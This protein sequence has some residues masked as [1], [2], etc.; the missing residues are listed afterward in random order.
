MPNT[1]PEIP[2]DVKRML[3]IECG[4]R[5]AA[6][7]EATALEK[8]HIV[9]WGS[10]MEHKFENLV[11]L[12]AVCHKN[13]HDD[14]WDRLAMRGY[15]KRPWVSRYRNQ[16][17]HSDKAVVHL[18]LDLTPETFGPEEKRRVLVAVAAALDICPRDVVTLS[19][20]AGSVTLEL[21]LP[22]DAAQ[23]LLSDTKVQAA[24]RELVLPVKLTAISSSNLAQNAIT[25]TPT[26]PKAPGTG[27]G[28]VATRGILVQTLVALLGVAQSESSFTEITLEPAVGNEQ[29]DFLWK[30]KEGS[31]AT[32]VKS[33]GNSF[34]KAD[35]RKWAGELEAARS[36]EQCRLM[37]VGNMPSS[38]VGLK[39]VGAVA[40]ETK[41]LHLGDL[42]E[43]AAHRLAAFLENEQQPSGTAAER[44]MVVHGLTSKLQHLAAASERF[45]REEFIKLLKQWV[46]DAPRQDRPIEISRIRKYAPAYLIGRD[47][48]IQL[49]HDAWNQTILG[50]AKRPNILTFVAF[51]GEGKTSLVAKWAAE[52][53][54][55][56]WPGCAAAFAWSFYI[57]G[58]REQVAASSDLFLKEALKFFA[59]GDPKEEEIKQFA[60][61]DAGPHAKGQRLASIVGQRRSLLILDGLEPLQYPPTAPMQSELKDE[62][63]AAL[64]RG[65]AAASH[66]L[67]VV[68]TRYSLPDLNAFRQTTAPEVK[69]LR[70]SP[71]AGVDLLKTLGV[72]GKAKEFETLVEDVKGHALTLTLL[73]SY[74]SEFHVGRIQNYDR[75]HLRDA[76]DEEQGGHAF[77][78]M[79]AY[80]HSLKTGGRDQEEN[81]KGRQALELL[82]LLGLF[83][84][85][86]T[87]DCLDALWNRPVIA[88]LT[89]ELV[90][91]DEPHRN[92][93]LNRLE[94]AKLLTVNRDEADALISL[95]AHPL[96]REYFAKQLREENPDAW[97][98]AH[99]RL[100]EHLCVTTLDKP[101]PALEDLQPLFQA[102]A[103]GCQAG[104]Y[105]R[106]WGVYWDRII[107]KKVS[108]HGRAVGASPAFLS[109]LAAFY[110][111]A[112]D[113]PTPSL[114]NWLQASLLRETG[115]FLFVLGRLEEAK[116]VLKSALTA[117]DGLNPKGSRHK[118]D[119][120]ATVARLLAELC[121]ITG[122]MEEAMKYA[123]KSVAIVRDHHLDRVVDQAELARICGYTGNKSNR[124][125][126]HE[127]F[128][129][130]E[131]SWKSKHPK[132]GYLTSFSGFWNCELLLD[133]IEASLTRKQIS[134]HTPTSIAARK[135]MC[136]TAQLRAEF[137]IQTAKRESGKASNRGQRKIDLALGILLLARTQLIEVRCGAKKIA[138]FEPALRAHLD[139]ALKGLREAGQQHHYANGLLVRCQYYREIGDYDSAQK[140]LDEAH[141][142]AERSKMTFH[143]VDHD[144]EAAELALQ[145]NEHAHAQECLDD[146]K[147][148]IVS[149]KGYTRRKPQVADLERRLRRAEA[150]WVAWRRP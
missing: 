61:S 51:G 98:E 59:E 66:G 81:K 73:G 87:A 36:T 15:K 97:H 9:P 115:H 71:E 1:R 42:V 104:Q 90:E 122:D 142:I 40:I 26:N 128:H 44:V 92:R 88:A 45:S 50:E 18:T 5:C 119:D 145:R 33:T 121:L 130:T 124:D 23:L 108:F 63:V 10:K 89:E 135:A 138:D 144:L 27:G 70:L 125:K 67:C 126:A 65:L 110:D 30:N 85:P 17:S 12:C 147:L 141:G 82:R 77:R 143:L 57:Q 117:F 80:V 120:V 64:L 83:D 107:Q 148:K 49:L 31:F 56:G 6:C 25:M 4:H 68:T 22:A 118:W 86:A 3:M 103:H 105:E 99:R 150:A 76:Y 8:A 136:E 28:S 19:I 131:E 84:R 16:C 38:L 54:G 55:E 133:E 20:R 75:V 46:K 129:E 102:V 116:E 114:P 29:F 146:A 47:V 100:C 112:W 127:L 93:A 41:N 91:L 137:V 96:V 58:T 95:D 74:L 78:V 24:L 109:C 123:S 149:M 139:D 94:A 134:R 37:L 111:R 52:L 53:A 35:V 11:V 13:S 72:K 140:D 79:D 7:G 113:Q 132:D 34:T 21:E 62:G 101:Q 69:L 48:E 106:A 43:Q 14:H 2:M 60:A 39:S 32:Q